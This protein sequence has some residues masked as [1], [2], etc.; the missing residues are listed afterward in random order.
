MMMFLLFIGLVWLLSRGPV[1]L[2]AVRRCLLAG[3]VQAAAVIVLRVRG[4]RAVYEHRDGGC[5]QGGADGD[6][7]DLRRAC[8]PC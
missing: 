3:M 1:R 2:G 7:G 4:R 5:D 6:Q 8:R